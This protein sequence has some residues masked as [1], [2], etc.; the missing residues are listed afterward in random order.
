MFELAPTPPNLRNQAAQQA[1]QPPQNR[2]A[3]QP[4]PQPDLQPTPQPAPKKWNADL[5][6]E[7]EAFNTPQEF[8]KHYNEL[9]QTNAPKQY[10]LDEYISTLKPLQKEGTEDVR[11]A[12]IFHSTGVPL[13]SAKKVAE[14]LRNAIIAEQKMGD[15]R[16]NE[17]T[18][19]IN[20]WGTNEFGGDF[21]KQ[22][23]AGLAAMKEFSGD[24]LAEYYLHS[25]KNH[26]DFETR[27]QMIR[28]VIGT[29]PLRGVNTNQVDFAV[30]PLTQS[31]TLEEIRK[32]MYEYINKYGTIEAASKDPKFMELNR[33]ALSLQQKR[34]A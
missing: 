4:A 21:E 19:S 6:K 3:P 29:K 24:K 32:D 2:E 13:E 18:N 27:Q 31:K 5:G 1:P 33:A 17:I 11:L 12:E 25:I 7:F 34:T 8:I 9:K 14:H 23:N 30:N 26:P 20:L 22:V 15:H 28:E 16:A 10:A